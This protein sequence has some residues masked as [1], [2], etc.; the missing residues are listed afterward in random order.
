[1]FATIRRNFRRFM[2]HKVAI[3]R[4][5]QRSERSA[6]PPPPGPDGFLLRRWE[7]GET[8]RLNK[9]HWQKAFGR[10]INEDL[11]DQLPMLWAR[12]EYEARNN[13]MVA[14]VIETHATDIVGDHGPRLQ[15]QSDDPAFNELVEQAWGEFFA[16]P[17]RNGAICGPEMIK[18]WIRQLWTF[19]RY[20]NQIDHRDRGR[21]SLSSLAIKQISANRLTTPTHLVAD[22][23]VAFGCRR[24]A[25]G[26][27]LMFYI[28]EPERRGA[29]IVRDIW[30]P[31]PAD[32]I[33]HRFVKVDPEQMT[34]IPWLACCL[35]TIAELRDCDDEV[36]S[37][38]RQAA[39][40]AVFWSTEHPDAEIDEVPDCFDIE[41][42]KQ[43][44]GPVGWKPSMLQPTQPSTTYREFRN[45]KLR[46]LG[47]PVNMPLMM[48]LLSS[49]DSNF[50]S[51]H[52]DGQI[53]T[54]GVSGTQNQLS[55]ETLNPL[56][57]IVARDLILAR[58]T[59][60]PRGKI[61]YSW[62]WPVPPYVNPQQMYNALRAR[63]E[64]GTISYPDVLAAYGQ[65]E[66]TVIAARKRTN[67]KIK[68]AGLPPLPVNM[69]KVPVGRP[70]ER[71]REQTAKV[72][73]TRP[74]GQRGGVYEHEHETV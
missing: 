19:G 24:D 29:R 16:S 56:V 67:E 66:D 70:D 58:K 74:T 17:D 27:E 54:R 47:R 40:T 34:G 25:Y 6:T 72:T 45:E 62:T 22:P 10:S 71:T 2:G 4:P 63:L 69:G 9:S 44:V 1:M 49:A 46:E 26:A 42:G 12:C 37:A 68:Q 57:D 13:P 7:S 30:K 39:L 41:K 36:L 35:S 53:Y 52:Y 23:D 33:Q 3:S 11:A 59:R 73:K 55:R 5:M 51:A 8:H 60:R 20:V 21:D 18:I 50:S 15:V 64:D 48:V 38:I 31:K 61:S 32:L 65:D 14:G 43:H 28:N